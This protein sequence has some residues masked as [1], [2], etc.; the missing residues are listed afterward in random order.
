MQSNQCDS[1]P[2]CLSCCG[3]KR[4]DVKDCVLTWRRSEKNE[5][6]W[7]PF[8]SANPGECVCVGAKGHDE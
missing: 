5:S 2:L 6:N 7:S 1:L 8:Q 3:R 4:N